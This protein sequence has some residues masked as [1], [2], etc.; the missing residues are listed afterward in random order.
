LFEFYLKGVQL[1]GAVSIQ[2]EFFRQRA[3]AIGAVAARAS[4]YA[5]GKNDAN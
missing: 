3:L 1:R 2:V 5:G 4:E